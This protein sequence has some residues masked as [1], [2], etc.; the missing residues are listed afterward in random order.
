MNEFPR[1]YACSLS[2]RLLR[3][4][5]ILLELHFILKFYNRTI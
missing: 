1:R 5:A 3:S 2:L 4:Q